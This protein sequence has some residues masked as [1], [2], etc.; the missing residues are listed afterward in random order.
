MS[1]PPINPPK[2]TDIPQK[3]HLNCF[4]SSSILHLQNLRFTTIK[5][6]RF[7]YPLIHSNFCFSTNMPLLPDIFQSSPCSL[8]LSYSMIHLFTHS[9][10][11]R[12]IHPQVSINSILF[13]P[14][15]I[16]PYI[17]LIFLSI[18]SY[19]HNFTFTLIYCQLPSPTHITKF[20][21]QSLQLLLAVTH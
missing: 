5:Q 21:H 11:I 8:C 14:F 6:T 13:Q 18:L 10:V 4:H 1:K 20:L 3:I 17:H 9:T 2:T 7:N 12:N 16:Q 15:T 19:S